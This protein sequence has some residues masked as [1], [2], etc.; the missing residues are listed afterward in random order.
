MPPR[1]SLR[2]ADWTH[3]GELLLSVRRSVFCEEQG[4]P[5]AIEIDGRD[6]RCAH[7]AAV[8]DD[9]GHVIAT[10]RMILDSPTDAHIGRIAV[11]PVYRGQGIGKRIV[12]FFIDDARRRGLTQLHLNAQTDT[13]AFYE[14][15]GFNT[16][17]DEFLEADIPHL[18]MTL[19]LPPPPPSE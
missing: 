18:A 19:K 15:L 11:L 13:T 7:V 4:V 16:N 6:S 10:G 17:G 3:M 2:P 8:D 12:R 9:T 14:A 5:E 1:I